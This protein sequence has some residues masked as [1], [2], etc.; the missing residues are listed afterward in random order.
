MKF[1]FPHYFLEL[2]PKVCFDL[3]TLAD[4]RL[5]L[6]ILSIMESFESF[7]KSNTDSIQSTLENSSE[8]IEGWI[9]NINVTKKNSV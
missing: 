2:K 8:G 5:I 6:D 3:K 4:L 9:C 1:S 7:P